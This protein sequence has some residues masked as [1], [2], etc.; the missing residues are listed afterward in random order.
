MNGQPLRKELRSYVILADLSDQESE[1]TKM[2]KA[3]MGSERF[4]QALTTGNPNSTVGKDKWA[5]GQV[6]IYM[7][8]KDREALTSSIIKNFAATANR[9]NHHDEKQLKS[10]IYLD[11]VN[12]GLGK[13][14][15]SR[16]G[17]DMQI[18]GEYQQ[19]I[20]DSENELVWLRKDTKEATLNIVVS[21]KDYTDQKQLSKEGLIEVINDFGEKFV[22]SD[23]EGDVLV[24]NTEDLP[25]YEYSSNID[26]QYTKELRGTWEMTKAFAAGPFISY[27]I[28]SAESNSIIYITTF[29]LA[30]GTPKRDMMMQ[31]DYIVK[32]AKVSSKP[33]GS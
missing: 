24:V 7:F 5:R 26:N 19:V 17:V 15:A 16:F 4:N 21:R 11:R 31:L 8:G 10:S 9:I 27:A 14:I 30:P 22:T 2:V 32:H 12:I 33:P 25:I 20:D 1:T 3:D 13:E 23:V 29:V 28:H 18:P 6:L